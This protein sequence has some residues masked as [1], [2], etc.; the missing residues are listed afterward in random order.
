MLRQQG[1]DDAG[2]ALEML[3]ANPKFVLRNHLAETAI[4]RAQASDFTEVQRLHRVLQRP[5]D[6]QPEHEADA[7]FP[8]D[9]AASLSI[10][11]S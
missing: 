2:R 10:S 8:P 5:Y 7:G 1:R 9:W 6:E 3:Q 11:C 4:R